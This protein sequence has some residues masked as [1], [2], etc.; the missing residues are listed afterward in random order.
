MPSPVTTRP[1]AL[2]LVVSTLAVVIVVWL[3]GR[4]SG[5]RDRV[6]SG[7]DIGVDARRKSVAIEA[8]ASEDRGED[9]AAIDPAPTAP[10]GAPPLAAQGEPWRE[11]R[12]NEVD[13]QLAILR[14]DK[15]P[16][17]REMTVTYLVGVC[18][19]PLADER[20]LSQVRIRDGVMR[21]VVRT[22][23]EHYM[24]FGNREYRVPQ[25]MFPAFDHLAA[26]R[27][28]REKQARN[29]KPKGFVPTLESATE[30]ANAPFPLDDANLRD[31]EAMV[32]EAKAAIA[33]RV[34]PY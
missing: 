22:P 29:K 16:S 14:E 6:E 15:D 8:P 2:L 23:N 28:E 1:T 13:Q 18:V 5:A 3:V 32:L 27:E 26:V 4:G 24:V 30:A 10:E 12:L 21:P 33:R 11:L 19:A 25:G 9:R 20:G 34:E 31:I 7:A 17:Q